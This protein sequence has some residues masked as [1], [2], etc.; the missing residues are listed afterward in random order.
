MHEWIELFYLGEDSEP[1]GAVVTRIDDAEV[2]CRVRFATPDGGHGGGE[3]VIRPDGSIQRWT[4]FR[5]SS[6]GATQ[7]VARADRE[8]RVVPSYGLSALVL[9]LVEG[10]ESAVDF[11]LLDESDPDAPRA[12]H[13]ERAGTETV[14]SP[15]RGQL[16]ACVRVELTADGHRTNTYWVRD[17]IVVV[18]DWVGAR[19]YAL[20]PAAA[21]GLRA[22]L[23]AAARID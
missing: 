19:S 21:Q 22:A 14:H 7:T 4:D 12:A 1:A 5:F 15:L 11:L 2:S 17:G 8:G 10:P 16:A 23:G 6:D 3:S 20:P 18:S 9:E 13:L